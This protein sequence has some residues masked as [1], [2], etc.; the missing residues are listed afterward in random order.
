MGPDQR[1]ETLGLR[2]G[3]GA[4]ASNLLGEV[5]SGL[6][7]GIGV[8]VVGA[9][10]DEMTQHAGTIGEDVGHRPVGGAGQ[11]E[12]ALDHPLNAT[13]LFGHEIGPTASDLGIPEALVRRNGRK[14]GH[15]RILA[16]SGGGGDTA[17]R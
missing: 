11:L 1:G 8:A 9:R 14:G 3:P 2:V 5:A 15:T 4:V 13:R 7:G 17:C 12:V 6:A 16:P 10:V